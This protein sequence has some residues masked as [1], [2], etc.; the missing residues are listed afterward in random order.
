MTWPRKYEKYCSP[1]L[2]SERN[3]RVRERSGIR[4]SG[5][6]F[7]G[8]P[9][10]HRPIRCRDRQPV[11][12]TAACGH[13]PRGSIEARAFRKVN[14]VAQEARHEGH[15]RSCH[16]SRR[17]A[18]PEYVTA[19][20]GRTTNRCSLQPKNGPSAAA[21]IPQVLPGEGRLVSSWFCFFLP[22]ESAVP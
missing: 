11:V 3:E 14:A 17:L 1:R 12:Q 13:I 9:G 4:C 8:M 20:S 16:L 7:L 2:G 18:R 6:L 22:G 19:A 5:G 10:S 15:S 21:T